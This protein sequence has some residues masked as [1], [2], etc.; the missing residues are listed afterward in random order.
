MWEDLY[1][2]E[3][4]LIHVMP[5]TMLRSQAWVIRAR[6]REI[7]PPARSLVPTVEAR[8][9]GRCRS[10]DGDTACRDGNIARR[11]AKISYS[12]A[13]YRAG[14]ADS[15]LS[16]RPLDRWG[17]ADCC[18][19]IFSPSFCSPD[20]RGGTGFDTTDRV[21]KRRSGR[22]GQSAEAFS[23][24][25]SAKDGAYGRSRNAVRAVQPWPCRSRRRVFALLLFFAFWSH[26]LQ[27]IVFPEVSRAALAHPLTFGLLTAWS[28]GAGFAER[29]VPA[30]R[31]RL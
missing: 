22:L 10:A 29:F 17:G 31:R 13:E 18:R 23:M 6:Y 4:A 21:R 27:G 26:A 28:F 9:F 25:D 15:F 12:Y 16:D 30:A 7:V 20:F 8:G 24:C 3:T 5:E 2:L 14:T 11:D 1:E 19:G